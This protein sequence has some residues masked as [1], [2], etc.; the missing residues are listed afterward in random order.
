[1]AVVY[2]VGDL[3]K[4]GVFESK[5]NIH[6]IPCSQDGFT[7][8]DISKTCPCNPEPTVEGLKIVWSHK[9]AS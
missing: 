4:W 2:F 7:N 3:N 6:V 5:D 9:K 8:H 1:M